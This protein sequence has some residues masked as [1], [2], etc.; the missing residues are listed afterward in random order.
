M[1]GKTD[2]KTMR[3]KG[4]TWL[5]KEGLG[6]K[7]VRG[8]E[9]GWILEKNHLGLVKV[10]SYPVG[11]KKKHQEQQSNWSVGFDPLAWAK[12][13]GVGNQLL[14]LWK[15]LKKRTSENK[16]GLI[17]E[18]TMSIHAQQFKK[19]SEHPPPKGWKKR[20]AVVSTGED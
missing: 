4:G 17:W 6:E 1:G 7:P 11:G 2:V 15:A 18:A 10:T 20:E 8:G 3:A 5:R 13:R 14:S 12:G 16:R 9:G 19:G